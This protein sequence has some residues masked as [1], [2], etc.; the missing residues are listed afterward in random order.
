NARPLPPSGWLSSR[1]PRASL[2]TPPSG[3]RHAI[4]SDRA[5]APASQSAAPRWNARW[6]APQS[7]LLAHRP[8]IVAAWLAGVALLTARL[9]L[10]LIGAERARRCGLSIA[11]VAIQQ[12]AAHLAKQLGLRRAVRVAESALVEA[13]TL[14]C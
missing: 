6:A 9:I 4:D 13:P 14:V 10:G 11:A 2:A 1:L 12:R 3:E 7:W 5:T 8:W